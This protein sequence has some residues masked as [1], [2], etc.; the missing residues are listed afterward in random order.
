[1]ASAGGQFARLDG[2]TWRR[3]PPFAQ[4]ADTCP[5]FIRKVTQHA[6]ADA[7]SLLWPARAAGSRVALQKTGYGRTNRTHISL[8]DRHSPGAYYLMGQQSAREPCV[9]CL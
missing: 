3:N 9:H 5:L 4:L 7:A 6:T 8:L 1:M 2:P